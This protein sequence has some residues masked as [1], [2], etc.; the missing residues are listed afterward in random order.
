MRNASALFACERG[1]LRH[2][3]LVKAGLCQRT[4]GTG[5]GSNASVNTIVI[6]SVLEK[7]LG[8]VAQ[9]LDYMANVVVDA[10]KSNLEIL[11]CES[12]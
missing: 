6:E 10:D 2:C 7:G 11:V 4:A 3:L 5:P 9:N 8:Y 12:Q 1:M